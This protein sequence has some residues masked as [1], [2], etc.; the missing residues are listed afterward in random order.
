M[1]KHQHNAAQRITIAV[2]LIVG[3]QVVVNQQ[4]QP[5]ALD[6]RQDFRHHFVNQILNGKQGGVAFPGVIFQHIGQLDF[7]YQVYQRIRLAGEL[8]VFRGADHRRLAGKLFQWAFKRVA[9]VL[10]KRRAALLVFLVQPLG[11]LQ[12]FVYQ[13]FTVLVANDKDL[14]ARSDLTA[15][16]TDFVQFIIYGGL[17]HPLMLIG[18]RSDVL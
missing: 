6:N 4:L 8:M 5:F 3:R 1:D 7:I 14:R 18:H 9:D 16:L 17:N 12:L 2:A 10:H 13:N 11:L 15:E